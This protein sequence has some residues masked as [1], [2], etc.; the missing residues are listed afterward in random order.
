M[1]FVRTVTTEFL[2]TQVNFQ[3]AVSE[4]DQGTVEVSKIIA[5]F[6][7]IFGCVTLDVIGE[8]VT[9][10]VKIYSCSLRIHGIS[11]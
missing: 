6:M 4:E 1:T 11:D 7:I 10:Q 9:G 2:Q 3:N 8:N 5:L